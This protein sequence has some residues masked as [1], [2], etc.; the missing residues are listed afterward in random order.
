MSGVRRQS[1]VVRRAFVNIFSVY[2]LEATILI[3]SSSNLHR[4]FVLIIS[5]TS[6]NMGHIGPISRSPGQKVGQICMNLV[7]KLEATYLAQTSSNLIRMLIL[8]ISGTSSNMGQVRLKSRSVGQI[9]EKPCLCSRGHIFCPIFFKL[10]QDVY[11]DDVW[12]KLEFGSGRLK[13]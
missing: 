4:M 1:C 5:W 9:L 6:S 2:A 12:A 8:M 7:Y 10:G 3:G 11:L 13:K